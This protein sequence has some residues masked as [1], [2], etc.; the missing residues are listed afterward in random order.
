MLELFKDGRDKIGKSKMRH[1]RVGVEAVFVCVW[2]RKKRWNGPE[3][4]D[5][6]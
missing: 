6:D 3:E 1:G 4:A 2:R 5:R